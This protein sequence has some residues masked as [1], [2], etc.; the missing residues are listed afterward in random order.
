MTV[1]ALQAFQEAKLPEMC[2][3]NGCVIVRHKWIVTEM[4]RRRNALR[5]SA[6]RSIAWR[7]F[8]S[9]NAVPQPP[10]VAHWAPPTA[11]VP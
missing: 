9:S 7:Y 4:P 2:P 5:F 8:S 11:V 1:N 10:L 6:L 3:L